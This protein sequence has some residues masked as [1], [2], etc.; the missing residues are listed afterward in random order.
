VDLKLVSGI[1]STTLSG[2]SLRRLGNPPRR[3]V[4]FRLETGAVSARPH[5][6]GASRE[7]VVWRDR[8]S[9]KGVFPAARSGGRPGQRPLAKPSK[10]RK[11]RRDRPGTVRARGREH[12]DDL[13]ALLNQGGACGVRS[14]GLGRHWTPAARAI[15]RR[16]Q[17]YS[18]YRVLHIPPASHCPRRPQVTMAVALPDTLNPASPRATLQPSFG[19]W[20]IELGRL[21]VSADEKRFR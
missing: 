8:P 18:Q 1:R 2:G 9:R 5:T 11:K 6:P 7:S 17:A 10:A 16:P 15:V 4:R 12:D 21:L 13:H 19:Y 20:T 3:P 14:T